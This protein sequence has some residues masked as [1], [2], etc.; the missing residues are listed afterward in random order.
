MTGPTFRHRPGTS[1][2]RRAAGFGSVPLMPPLMPNVR[3][4]GL[5][6]ALPADHVIAAFVVGKRVSGSHLRH[7][8]PFSVHGRPAG[9]RPVIEMKRIPVLARRVSPVR[10][11]MDRGFRHNPEVYQKK[12]RGG[13]G[14]VGL[15]LSVS[16]R[17]PHIFSTG[18]R[19][20]GVIWGQVGI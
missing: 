2:R 7:I 9:R 16:G 5:R 19:A 10:A 6:A 17:S 18:G 1:N 13:G 3:S 20:F 4:F 12:G 14:S 8:P 11:N 15:L